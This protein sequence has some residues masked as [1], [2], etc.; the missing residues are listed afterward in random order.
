MIIKELT[1]EVRKILEHGIKMQTETGGHLGS[2]LN[3]NSYKK[4]VID[5]INKLYCKKVINC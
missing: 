2:K 5:C 4:N 3:L 1:P